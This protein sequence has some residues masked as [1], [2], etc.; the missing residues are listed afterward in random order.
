VRRLLLARHAS[1]EATRRR[2][3]PADE[4]LDDDG[5]AAAA[6]LAGVAPGAEVLCSP[7]LRCRQTAAAAGLEARIDPQLAECDFG[8]WAGRTGDEIERDRPGDVGRW[9][10]DPEA[11]PGG[12]ESLVQFGA[13]VAGWLRSQRVADGD[14]LVITHGGVIRAAATHA[15]RSPLGTIFNLQVDPLS[16]TELR[17][18]CDGWT[19]V[20]VN[21]SAR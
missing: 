2:A 19:V 1:T 20:G 4:P 6:V 14:A 13:R 21:R 18:E 7:A 17:A 5:R 10:L 12:G 11:R 3:F 16:I 8:A 15:L 9:I